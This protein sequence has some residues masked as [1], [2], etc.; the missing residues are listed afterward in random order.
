[1]AVNGLGSGILRGGGVGSAAPADDVKD[2]LRAWI[3]ARP[4]FEKDRWLLHAVEHPEEAIGATLRAAFR[5]ERSDG[6]APVR[7]TARELLTRAR[8][9]REAR[10]E[11]ENA[12]KEHARVAAAHKRAKTLDR[13]AQRQQAAWTDV[14]K[15]IEAR[16]YDKAVALAVDLRELAERDGTSQHFN[17]RFAFLKKAHARRRGFFDAFKRRE[18]SR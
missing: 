13:L 3:K 1:M 11:R 8:E 15:L 4:V 2:D 5:K 14:T 6:V 17:E 12:A 7:R 16:S 18:T 9:L 10:T